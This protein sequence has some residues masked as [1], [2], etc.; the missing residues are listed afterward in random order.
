ML[1]DVPCSYN[2]SSTP[3]TAL[4][5]HSIITLKVLLVLKDNVQSKDLSL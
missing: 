2:I 5:G 4:S 1:M 3:L